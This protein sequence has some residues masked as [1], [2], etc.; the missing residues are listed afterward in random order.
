[1]ASNGPRIL[2]TG[3]AGFIGSHTVGLLLERGY[4]PVVFDNLSTGRAGNLPP[5]VPLFQADILDPS[6][7]AAAIEGCEGVIHLAAVVSVP[8]SVESPS[9]THAVNLTGTL[10]V[11]E[12]AHSA[13][14]K[15][16]V[17][18]SSAAVY[19]DGEP[20]LVEQAKLKPL[21]PYALE[22]L[23]CELYARLYSRLYGLHAL[24]LRYF[25]VYGPR[26]DPRSPY[27]GVLSRFA[28][29]LAASRAGEIH[30]DG[31]QTRDFVFVGDVAAA[32]I[33]ALEQAPHL[34]GS[35][36]NIGTGAPTS[37]E[38]AYA[39]ICGVLGGGP[40]PRFGQER[41]G[42]VRHSLADITKTRLELGWEPRVSF[43]EGLRATLSTFDRL[44]AA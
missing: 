36:F 41:L 31:Q 42:D 44:E 24:A 37:I 23:G 6:A 5:E 12:A 40:A 26:Q 38:Q 29:S 30:G 18:A 15:P 20:P 8:K 19:G 16:V 43:A 11:L 7:L 27:S 2:V 14:V 10:N 21:S 35:I 22:K 9:T 33:R 39:E 1:M 34:A 32:N 28:E 13:G 3:G 17:L 25:N 4:H